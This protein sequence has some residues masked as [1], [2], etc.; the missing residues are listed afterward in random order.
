MNAGILN[1]ARSES[2]GVDA[3]RDVV[4]ELLRTQRCE[5]RAFDLRGIEIAPCT[6]CFGCWVRT[7]GVCTAEGPAREIPAALINADL[8]VFLTPVTFG[9]YSSQL[10]KALD[11][12]IGLISPHF[13][14]IGGEYHH[15]PRY[16]KHPILL[17]LGVQEKPDPESEA[18]FRKLVSRNAINFFAPR[19]AAGVVSSGG[20][21]AA[22]RSR[23]SELLGEAGLGS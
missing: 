3:V 2:D 8:A 11:H 1:G 14:K 4:V 15:K 23:I 19:W 9:G 6:G 22:M 12:C 18:I 17:G 7:P 16:G 20:D 13:K 10:K 5:A 21:P